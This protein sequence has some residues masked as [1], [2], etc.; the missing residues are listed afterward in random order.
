MDEHLLTA[1]ECAHRALRHIEAVVPAA[2][3][4]GVLLNQMEHHLRAARPA[5]PAVEPPQPDHEGEPESD[6]DAA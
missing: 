5:P 2:S 3:G 6:A 1:L 4:V